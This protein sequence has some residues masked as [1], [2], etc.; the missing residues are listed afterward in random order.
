MGY[1]GSRVALVLTAISE[2]SRNIIMYAGFGEIILSRATRD[3]QE[4]VQ[5]VARDKG[6]GIDDVDRVLNRTSMGVGA[7]GL[8]LSGLQLCMDHFSIDSRPGS[9]TRV[10]CEV[11]PD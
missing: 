7:S 9:G 4:A 3:E 1:S 5:V 2:L 8:G 6:P 11:R 10:T